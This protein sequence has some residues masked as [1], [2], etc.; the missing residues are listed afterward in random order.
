MIEKMKLRKLKDVCFIKPPKNESKSLLN[1]NDLVS[2]VPMSDLG[3]NQKYI[4]INESK[5]LEKVYSSYTYFKENDVL[6]AKITPCFEN[7]KLG[8]AKNLKNGIGFGSSEYI[9]Y[10]PK[11]KDE[12]DS[13]Y[14]YY[15]L[16]QES[17]RKI[18]SGI[19]TGAVGHK[20][21]PKDF[22]EDFLI[23]LPE[24]I[25]EQKQ[26]VEILDKTFEAIDKAKVNIEKNIQNTKELFQSKL[27]EIFSQKGEGWEEKTLGEVCEMI[28]RGISPKY[29]EEDGIIVIN[30]KC[31]RDHK[32][33]LSLSRLHNS[34]LKAVNI[35]R[36]IKIGDVLI[37]ST[38]TGTLGRIA[39]VRNIEL[40]GCTIDSHV[41]IV[42]PF[43]KLF[44]IDFFGYALI[45]IE[46]EIENSGEGTSGQTEL[47]RVKLQNDFKINYPNCH[48]KQKEIVLILDSLKINL[49]NIEQKYQQKLKNLEELKKSILEK[50]FSGEL[51]V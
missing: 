14:L 4:N 23:P 1:N 26:I 2:F 9:V 8:I 43:N 27:N 19:M 11:L 48:K 13:E 42:R 40:E 51:L 15:F 7:G 18:G 24:N 37:N 38:G 6:L 41:T 49:K 5:E 3:I 36:I 35:E 28:K 22:Y 29:T 31:I 47:S 30:Q 21:I 33:N 39:Q 25:K 45:K 32:I 50:A 46:K 44:Y 17:F 16:S 34:S 10:R 12:I 20:R